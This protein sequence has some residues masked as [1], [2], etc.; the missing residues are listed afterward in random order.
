MNRELLLPP[1]ADDGTDLTHPMQYLAVLSV[2]LFLVSAAPVQAEDTFVGTE[3]CVACHQDLSGS[4]ART[5]HGKLFSPERGLTERMKQGCEACHGPGS[6][7]VAAG[8]GPAPAGM[9]SFA[10]STP[11]AIEAENGVASTV[12]LAASS[13]TGTAACTIRAGS[14]ARAATPRT[15]PT[16]PAPS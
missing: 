7:H 10:A 13:S 15:K 4:F 14:R 12:T 6:G 16:R 3:T 1:A 5:R 9:R 11:E 8:G 2:A